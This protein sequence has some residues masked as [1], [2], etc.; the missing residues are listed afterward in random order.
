MHHMDNKPHPLLL[1]SFSQAVYTQVFCIQAITTTISY[2][3]ALTLHNGACPTNSARGIEYYAIGSAGCC[4]S[5]A[6]AKTLNTKG[7]ACCP[8]G[9]FCTGYMPEVQDWTTDAAGALIVSTTVSG[10]PTQI[11]PATNTDT[12]STA[13]MFHGP[14]TA[15]NSSVTASSSTTAGSLSTSLSSQG[16]SSSP[17]QASATASSSGYGAVGAPRVFAAVLAMVLSLLLK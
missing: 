9:A 12:T 4:T 2:L 1:L 6:T 5:S 10:K 3:P 14:H 17:G 7:V 16:S 13:S 15:T 8:C 11:T